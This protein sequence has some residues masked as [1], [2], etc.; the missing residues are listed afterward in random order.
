[1]IADDTCPLCEFKSRGGRVT[2]VNRILDYAVTCPRCRS[3]EVTK[4]ALDEIAQLKPELKADISSWVA[5]R[6][7][8][9]G[10]NPQIVSSAYQRTPQDTGVV[11]VSEIRSIFLPRSFSERLDRVLLN[12]AKMSDEPGAPI[13]FNENSIFVCYSWST[14]MMSF[15]LAA[16]HDNA[17]LSCA[18]SV[19]GKAY[20]TP[21]GWNRVSTLE[22]Q[23]PA[24]NQVFVAIAFANE[25]EPAWHDGILKGVASANMRPIR[26]DEKE[27]NEKICDVIVAEIRRSSLVIADVTL[28]R[29]GVYFEAGYAMGLG[30]PVIWCCKADDIENVHFDTRQYNHIVWATPEELALKIERRIKATR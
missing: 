22:G 6:N 20:V 28:Q 3:F 13:E 25:L 16:L 19:P 30:I 4:Q 14:N 11:S 9:K 1:M 7:I 29:Q 8:Q 10:S 18:P 15:N 26:V 23:S 24:S 17:W 27:H 5:E 2:L 21:G 12:M